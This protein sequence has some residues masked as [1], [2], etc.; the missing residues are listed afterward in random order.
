MDE[1]DDGSKH[2]KGPLPTIE[3]QILLQLAHG[4]GHGYQMMKRIAADTGGSFAPGPATLYVALRRLSERGLI[5]TAEKSDGPTRRQRY[6]LTSIGRRILGRELEML[7]D[8]LRQA[9]RA[10]WARTTEDAP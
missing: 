4:P 2:H 8:I 3:L 6:R 1:P 7:D 10:G 9:R 5:R